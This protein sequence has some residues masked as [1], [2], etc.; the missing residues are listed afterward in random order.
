MQEQINAL[1]QANADLRSTEA[2][3]RDGIALRPEV[4]ELFAPHLQYKQMDAS[5]R[6]RTISAY[7]KSQQLPQAL[8][9]ANGLAA[10][11]V[12]EG[13]AKKWALTTLPAL[14]REALDVLR[15]AAVGL[16]AARNNNNGQARIVQL[17]QTLVDVIT[18]AS[19]N[20]QRM[21]RTQL[22]TI[23]DA[24]GT[25]GAM[26]LINLDPDADHQVEID[27]ADNSILQ[28]V[29]VDAMQEIKKYARAV[30][31]EKKQS[32]GRGGRGGRRGNGGKG[33]GKD[34]Y[35]NRNK[36]RSNNGGKGSYSNGG[37]DRS[38]GGKG[39]N[40]SGNGGGAPNGNGGN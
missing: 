22:E 9:D 10:K 11:A 30:Q 20:A 27:V 25:K 23:F 5:E 19:D 36:W 34:R 24:A 32:G 33:G 6:K 28:A 1:Q 38:Y 3:K 2:A 21:A 16:H 31:P 40:S 18:L 13:P 4:R 26:A 39:G 15:V 8:T 35:G 17:E 7:P 37:G 14:Q 12:G 29:H